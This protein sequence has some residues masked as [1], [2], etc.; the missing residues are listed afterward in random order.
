MGVEKCNKIEVS[1]RQV[2]DI[3]LMLSMT[4]MELGGALCIYIPEKG[5]S[6]RQLLLTYHDKENNK[7]LTLVICWVS[8]IELA[9]EL[10]LTNM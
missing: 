9:N 1:F 6:S 3:L 5:A 10:P 2:S 8:A 7:V 4:V